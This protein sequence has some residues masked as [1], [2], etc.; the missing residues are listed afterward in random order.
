MTTQAADRVLQVMPPCLAAGRMRG[1]VDKCVGVALRLAGIIHCED[2]QEAGDLVN[3]L[4]LDELLMLPFVLAAMVD[5]D[6]TPGELLGWLD[7]TPPNPLRRVTAVA[8]PSVLVS[9]PRPRRHDAECGTHTG[10]ESHRK[11]GDSP[12][13]PCEIAEAAWQRTRTVPSA[14]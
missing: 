8:P 12:C 11:H 10:W 4:T 13:E 14:A 5:V 3:Q 9:A 7:Y 6:K 1:A 2:P